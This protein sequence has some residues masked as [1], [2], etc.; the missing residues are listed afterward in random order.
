MFCT[1]C[2]ANVGDTNVQ[3]PS[4]GA[5]VV[6]AANGR[7]IPRQPVIGAVTI[8]TSPHVRVS[9]QRPGLVT[10]L[11]VLHLISAAMT[12][13]SGSLTIVESETDLSARLGVATL[14]FVF[15]GLFAMC[16]VGLLRLRPYGRKIQ[17]GFAWFGLLGI[18]VGTIL[19]IFLIRYLRKP[20][21]KMLFV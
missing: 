12:F 8:S 18:P 11:G 2:G 10:L 6:V 9:A 4:C 21:I 14:L 7:V 19:S 15:S 17:L 1:Q 5:P 20:A 13:L 16:G 3:C